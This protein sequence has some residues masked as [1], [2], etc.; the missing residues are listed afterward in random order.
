MTDGT[1]GV[2]GGGGAAVGASVAAWQTSVSVLAASRREE[3]GDPQ[4]VSVFLCMY[5]FVSDV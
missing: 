2:S 5:V 3:S 1:A 4:G